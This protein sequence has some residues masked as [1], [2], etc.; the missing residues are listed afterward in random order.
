VNQPPPGQVEV[1]SPDLTQR[2]GT[3]PTDQPIVLSNLSS[4]M[5]NLRW[6]A[7]AQEQGFDVV[8]T[9]RA[10]TVT[11]SPNAPTPEGKVT[12]ADA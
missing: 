9:A 6:P 8:G 4:G 2:L 3:Y 12:Y 7:T 10:I 11:V 1:W 5:Y